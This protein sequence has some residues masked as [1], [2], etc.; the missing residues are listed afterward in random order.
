MDDNGMIAIH[1]RIRGWMQCHSRRTGECLLGLL[2]SMH[3]KGEKERDCG[4]KIR[5]VSFGT[6]SQIEDNRIKK[7]QVRR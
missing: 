2:V 5:N 4:E 7:E 6:T 3:N 1:E